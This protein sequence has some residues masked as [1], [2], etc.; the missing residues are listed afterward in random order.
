[1]PAGGATV[2]PKN[3]R[4]VRSQG[5]ELAYH[6]DLPGNVFSCEANYTHSSST[7][8]SEDFPGDPAFNAQLVYVPLDKFSLSWR[9]TV[10]LD[11]RL[12]KEMGGLVSYAFV[13]HCY[14]TEDNTGLLP[15]HQLVN[16]SAR[17][18][19]V[20]DRLG[21]TAKVEI[22][23]LLNE[24]YQVILGYPMPGRS[25]RLTMGVEY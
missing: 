21:I 20:I 5:S 22:N 14:Y 19:F 18:R 23:N 2:T 3:L 9:T 12:V 15:S 4:R 7:K 11:G 25:F 1:M 24:D 6:W 16:V 17:S 8:I 10:H 13:G